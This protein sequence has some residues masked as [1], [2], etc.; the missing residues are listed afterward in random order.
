VD[1]LANAEVTW[2]I[3]PTTDEQTARELSDGFVLGQASTQPLGAGLGGTTQGA[4]DYWTD[5][6]V[7]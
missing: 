1:S 5:T 6:L 7:L 3:A 4:F 2:D